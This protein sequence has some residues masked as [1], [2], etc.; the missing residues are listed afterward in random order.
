MDQD[1]PWML[2]DEACQAP[3][4]RIELLLDEFYL[5]EEDKNGGVVHCL[6]QPGSQ[7]LFR[8]LSSPLREI[9]T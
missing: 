7:G 2:Q 8:L 4:G 5:K 3:A 1:V 9:P 6:E